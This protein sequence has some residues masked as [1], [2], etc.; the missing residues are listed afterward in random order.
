MNKVI[1]EIYAEA[2]KS[3][4]KYI[5]QVFTNNFPFIGVPF[6]GYRAI[7]D[8]PYDRFEQCIVNLNLNE[9]KYDT[10]EEKNSFFIKLSKSILDEIYSILKKIEKEKILLYFYSFSVCNKRIGEKF[11]KYQMNGCNQEFDDNNITKFIDRIIK[12]ALII[13]QKHEDYITEI[14]RY[15]ATQE[16]GIELLVKIIANLEENE[17]SGKTDITFDMIK[18]LLVL[19]FVLI[20]I[21]NTRQDL[22]KGINKNANFSTDIN[23]KI[24]VENLEMD[25]TDLDVSNYNYKFDE[26]WNEYNEKL[27]LE[28]DNGVYNKC[29]FYLYDVK[30]I[31]DLF[32]FKDNVIIE[33]KELYIN[34]I[35]GLGIE[36][37]R[38][39]KLFEY[40]TYKNSQENI[41][42]KNLYKYIN[43]ANNNMINSKIFIQYK[44]GLY[45]CY[46]YLIR[47]AAELFRGIVASN[48]KKYVDH[49]TFEQITQGFVNDVEAE[50]KGK[51]PKAKTKKNYYCSQDREIDIVCILKDKIYLIECK[52]PKFT[53]D[54][55]EME[56]GYSKIM[57]EY[58][59]QLEEEREAFE[60]NKEKILN[61]FSREGLISINFKEKYE[62]KPLLVIK[63]FSPIHLQ[64]K[65]FPILMKDTLITYIK[66]DIK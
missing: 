26:N 45:I 24:E 7:L 36:K 38:A 8:N 50:L 4:E 56:N 28:L 52:R 49:N 3:Y 64:E 20:L 62:I 19:S 30:L 57:K 16:D 17:N 32:C 10:N 40:F 15:F 44:D 60:S 61:E 1:N 37:E 2:V 65:T 46:N 23:G 27:F 33:T 66:N 42:E 43:Y 29:G 48:P 12:T 63:E 6:K 22:T 55:N 11:V 5:M 39:N 58:M 54:N 9:K 53:L 59:T 35:I 51:F 47:Y 25:L 34:K 21:I 31:S 13:N 14:E 18:D 41:N